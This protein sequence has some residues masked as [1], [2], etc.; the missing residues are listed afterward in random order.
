MSQNGKIVVEE[1]EKETKAIV[2]LHEEFRQSRYMVMK[3]R[4]KVS[5]QKKMVENL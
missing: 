4:T 5:Y 3:L 2:L 1:R